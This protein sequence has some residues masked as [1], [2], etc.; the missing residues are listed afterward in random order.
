[1]L[2]Y[3][4]DMENS[5][6]GLV[7]RFPPSFNAV[8]LERLKKN[9]SYNL[10]TLGD[11][12]STPG[13][14]PKLEAK[15]RLA[16]NLMNTIFDLHARGITHG[17]IVPTTVSFCDAA[18]SQPGAVNGEVDIRRP[19]L[20]S[21][22]LFSEDTPS[23]SP[24]LSRHPLDPRNSQT[25]P[26]AN[27]SDQR[28]L[29]LYSLATLLLS[30]G[31]WKK[32]EDIVPENSTRI[33]DSALEELAVRCGSLYTKA[34]QACWTAVGDELAGR[35]SGESLLSS[36]QVRCSRFLE[37]CC[38]LDGVSGLEER[39]DKELN[40]GEATASTTEVPTTMIN[41][42]AKDVKDFKS[43][44]KPASEKPMS[45]SAPTLGAEKNAFKVES[46]V[47]NEGMRQ[48]SPSSASC[49]ILTSS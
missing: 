32:L 13:S 40:P 39:L 27:N 9:P 31:L 20:S 48:H 10:P 41:K 49:E 26:L 5:R 38:I 21:F 3:F 12:L 24:I 46:A 4:E 28:V 30:V 33:P 16:H 11:L 17:N 19:L 14:E 43:P 18:T 22:D 42:D 37:A 36:V 23:A 25:S 6:L 45:A 44:L 35:S 15:F 34:V 2:G 29:D 47:D 7:Y 8:L 1:L